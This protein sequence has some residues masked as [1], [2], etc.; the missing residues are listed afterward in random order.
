MQ[1]FHTTFILSKGEGERIGVGNQI[2]SCK[3]ILQK[4]TKKSIAL[5]WTDTKQ[6]NQKSLHGL[7]RLF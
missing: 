1:L 6:F 2:L 3:L 4:N 7:K 5:Q